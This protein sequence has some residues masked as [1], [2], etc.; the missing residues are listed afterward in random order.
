MSRTNRFNGVRGEL[1][2][3]RKKGMF[4]RAET[5]SPNGDKRDRKRART[6]IKQQLRLE[7]HD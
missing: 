3:Q 4:A 1:A 2:E 7:G 6:R 5:Y